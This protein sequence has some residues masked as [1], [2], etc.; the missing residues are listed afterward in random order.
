MMVLAVPAERKLNIV[1]KRIANPDD[2]WDFGAPVSSY[3]TS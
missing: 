2:W 3:F 1:L